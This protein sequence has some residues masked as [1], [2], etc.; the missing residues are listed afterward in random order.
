MCL[1]EWIV[2]A[3]EGL[4]GL[5]FCTEN[6]KPRERNDGSLLLHWELGLKGT[7]LT[8]ES[9]RGKGQRKYLY[10]SSSVSI[11]SFATVLKVVL[12]VRTPCLRTMQAAV[13]ALAGLSVP[14]A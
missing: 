9:Q 12:P 4:Q 11:V 1:V 2:P 5:S 6:L 7:L 8:L 3:G 10:I 14:R 13:R